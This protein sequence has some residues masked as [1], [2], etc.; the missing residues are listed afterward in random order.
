MEVASGENPGRS[1]GPNKIDIGKL[2]EGVYFIEE[3]RCESKICE[4]IGMTN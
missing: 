3:G 2:N 1:S 4:E